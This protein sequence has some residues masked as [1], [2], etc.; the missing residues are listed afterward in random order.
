MDQTATQPPRSFLAALLQ[1][2]RVANLPSCL[3]GVLTGVAL[4][5]NGGGVPWGRVGAVWLAVCG[6][7]A[8]GA[9]LNDLCDWR[10]DSV[11]RPKRPL[12]SGRV[13]WLTAWWFVMGAF[14]VGLSI[15]AWLDA[16]A[17]VLG[18]VLC[19]VVVVYDVSHHRF[20]SMAPVLMGLC[21][22]LVYPLSAVAVVGAL[23]PVEAWAMA[24]GLAGY[25]ALLTV[26]GWGE[27]GRVAPFERWSARLMVLPAMLGGCFHRPE[28]WLWPGVM[29][30]LLMAWHVVVVVA[31]SLR[32]M[33]P[34]GRVVRAGISGICLVDAYYLSILGQQG[35]AGVAVLCFAVTCLAQRRMPGS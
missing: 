22:G 20:P 10:W 26:V 9:A 24:L 28:G 34:V 33:M 27:V 21:R 3:S 5:I 2:S 6:I 16:R 13:G 25:V 32:L 23:D 29:L 14:C 1:L 12:P 35:L 31:N 17:L 7:Y 30:G 8:G 18:A 19:A 11:T 4:S 15:L